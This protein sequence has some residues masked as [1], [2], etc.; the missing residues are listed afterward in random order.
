MKLVLVFYILTLFSDVEGH[1]CFGDQMNVAS[2]FRVKMEAARHLKHWYPT[3]S[4][5]CQNPK[6]H[7]LEHS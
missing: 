6:H 1:K 7:D 5:T 3:T 2:I 4:L